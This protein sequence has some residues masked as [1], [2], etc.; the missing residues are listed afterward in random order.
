MI[1]AAQDPAAFAQAL[2]QQWFLVIA[3]LSVTATFLYFARKLES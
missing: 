1:E 3:L 2:Q